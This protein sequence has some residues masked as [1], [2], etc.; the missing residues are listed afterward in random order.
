M[1]D[2]IGQC[3]TE[4][5]KEQALRGNAQLNEKKQTKITKPI[6]FAMQKIFKAPQLLI[7]HQRE[8]R[9]EKAQLLTNILQQKIAHSNARATS[10]TKTASRRPQ[11]VDPQQNQILAHSKGKVLK[12]LHPI[13]TQPTVQPKQKA[14][15]TDSQKTQETQCTDNTSL[16][17][18]T[19]T[20]HNRC[21]S[22]G[23]KAGMNNKGK[24]TL[25]AKELLK[26]ANNQVEI[27]KPTEPIKQMAHKAQEQQNQLQT[28]E[29]PKVEI[30]IAACIS[31]KQGN[32]ECIIVGRQIGEGAYATVR[33]A[34]HKTLGKKV[35]LKV[36][37]KKKLLEPQRQKSVYREIKLLEKMNHVNIVKLYDAFDTDRH[38]ILVMEYIRGH[39]LHGYLK[40]QPERK[41]EECEAKKL[42]KQVINGI[43]YCHSK[44]I[45]HRD[46]KLE[47]LLLNENNTVKIIDFGFSTCIPN[48]KKIKIFCGTPSYM[49]PE[50]VLRKE[51]AG[52]P[53]DVWALGVLLYA[54]LC[55]C[56]PFKGRNDKEL[57]RRISSCQP[58]MPEYLSIQAKSLLQRIFQ[59]DPEKR[60]TAKQ[61]L[62]DDWFSTNI[63]VEPNVGQSAG[64]PKPSSN[65]GINVE[66]YMAYYNNQCYYPKNLNAD[67]FARGL[68]QLV[69]N[70]IEMCGTVNNNINIIN[71]ITQINC[72]HDGSLNNSSFTSKGGSNCS[73]TNPNTNQSNNISKTGLDASKN[74]SGSVDN[75]L[76]SSIVKLGYPIDDVMNQLQNEN[77][78]I[79]K[80]YTKLMDEKKQLNVAIAPQVIPSITSSFDTLKSNLSIFN[81]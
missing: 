13:I 35:A 7:V 45:T 79:H 8:E 24:P 31:G 18:K 41:F 75:D 60:P 5:L 1:I 78:H 39:S 34:F 66:A 11:Q 53:A 67:L 63:T 33:L 19:T 65:A 50:I 59:L 48:T 23:I 57:Y 72:N 4:L 9:D 68:K 62:S 37:K 14:N 77:S 49:S 52:P 27:Q 43:E 20:T 71:N 6:S 26:K 15:Q 32:L 56:F 74:V 55:G 70:N 16:K 38:V 54:M 40:A 76:V 30:E 46:I 3:Q 81:D 61:I 17:D 29:K 51:Y 64:T 21:F 80:L 73:L 2:P 28:L 10:A 58:L 22:F 44:S 25:Q 47:N 36:Y 42:F 12:T 69:T